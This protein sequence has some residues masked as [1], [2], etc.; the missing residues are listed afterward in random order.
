MDD[1]KK[2]KVIALF[3]ANAEPHGE[4]EK[5]SQRIV[6]D[7]NILAGGNIN[8]NTGPQFDP[9]NPNLMPCPIC[10]RAV[11]R[12][13]DKCSGCDHNLA[14]DRQR[15]WEEARDARLRNVVGGL[16]VFALCSYGVG[17]LFP[18]VH[19][20]ATIITAIAAFFILLLLNR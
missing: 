9:S 3:K 7:G 11:S 15:V 17:Q 20:T 6:G 16:F 5:Q 4:Q 8:I 12:S 10:G 18:S 14:R 13:A 2:D 1:D 19:A